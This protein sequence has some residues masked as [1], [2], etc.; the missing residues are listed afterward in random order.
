MKKTVRVDKRAY[1]E[2]RK[3]PPEV[4]RKFTALFDLLEDNGKLEE[5]F[6]KKLKGEKL[7]EIRVRHQGQWRAVYSYLSGDFIIVLCAFKK[8][9]QKTPLEQISKA[10]KRLQF[11]QPKGGEV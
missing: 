11:L 5:P 3:F 9:A 8:K 10:H 1:K 7:F 2:L 4:Y 6:A